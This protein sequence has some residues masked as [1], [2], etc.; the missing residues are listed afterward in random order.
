ML[1]PQSQIKATNLERVPAPKQWRQIHHE[2]AKRGTNPNYILLQTLEN[3][4][5]DKHF[6]ESH[7]I[8]IQK[9]RGRAS[10]KLKMYQERKTA[11]NTSPLQ[12][13]EVS[14]FE[15]NRTQIISQSQNQS[16]QRIL[17]VSGGTIAGGLG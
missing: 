3:L 7:K 11:S 14:R 17:A 1:R 5:S 6:P 12:M 8:P 9:H 13:A 15:A 10:G 16:P 4:N 2:A